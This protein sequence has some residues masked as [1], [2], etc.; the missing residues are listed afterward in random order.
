MSRLSL[1]E[2]HQ[3]KSKITNELLGK[4][5]VDGVIGVGIVPDSENGQ[6]VWAIEIVSKQS[7][8]SNIQRKLDKIFEDE[9]G[10]K[11]ELD[12]LNFKKGDVGRSL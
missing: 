6:R 4:S 2:A 12:D 10:R 9:L 3:I 8:Q 7:L 5:G 1:E 11:P